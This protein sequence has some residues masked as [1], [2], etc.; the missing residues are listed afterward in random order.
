MKSLNSIKIFILTLLFK[1]INMIAF[2]MASGNLVLLTSH[3]Y[4]YWFLTVRECKQMTTLS[5]LKFA[6]KNIDRFGSF[7]WQVARLHLISYAVFLNIKSTLKFNFKTV[8]DQSSSPIALLKPNIFS[9]DMS[10]CL[11]LFYC[12]RQTW[13]P[14]WILRLLLVF[15]TFLIWN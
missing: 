4:L 15:K 14:T 7:D 3:N 13:L 10:S 2:T 8:T 1:S 11:V 6:R 9:Q 5:Q 12:F